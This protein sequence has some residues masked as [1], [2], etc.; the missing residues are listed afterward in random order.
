[1][2]IKTEIAADSMKSLL[3]R[4]NHISKSVGERGLRTP[5]GDLLNVVG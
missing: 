2:A 5:V 3:Q 1:M 4:F